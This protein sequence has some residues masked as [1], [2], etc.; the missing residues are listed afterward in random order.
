VSVLPGVE[1][2]VMSK[3][4]PM[5]DLSD[6]EHKLLIDGLTALRRKCGQAWTLACNATDANGKRRPSLR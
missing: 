5:A 2:Y 1:V 3:P 4:K 6:D